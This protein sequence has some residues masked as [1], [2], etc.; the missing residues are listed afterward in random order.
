LAEEQAT[1]VA[2]AIDGA[3]ESIQEFIS[4]I[5]RAGD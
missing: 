3:I 4:E 2:G 5:D 1:G